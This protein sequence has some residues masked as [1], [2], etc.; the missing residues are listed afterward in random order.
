MTQSDPKAVTLAASTSRVRMPAPTWAPEAQR[1]VND[2]ATVDRASPANDSAQKGP[3]S[4][5]S[6]RLPVR[7]QT[8]R[9]LSSN[10]GTVP[11]AVAMTF[12]QPAGTAAVNTSAPSTAML[13]AVETTETVL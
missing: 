6:E 8:H 11:A 13:T 7:R 9:R 10:D 1:A 3:I 2:T 4:P 12:A 5:S